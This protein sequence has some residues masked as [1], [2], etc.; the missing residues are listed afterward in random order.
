[1]KISDRLRTYINGVHGDFFIK[2]ADRIDTLQENNAAMEVVLQTIGECAGI[3]H[4][5]VD[6]LIEWAERN[7]SV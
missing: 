5:D 4:G 3:E 1:M 2:A 7:K 6:G